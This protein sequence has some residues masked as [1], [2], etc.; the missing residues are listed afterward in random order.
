MSE[1]LTEKEFSD[2]GFTI[3][4]GAD[5]NGNERADD[6]VASADCHQLMDSKNVLVIRTSGDRLSVVRC[7]GHC[8]ACGRG[9]V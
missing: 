4:E 6:R 7:G 8:G 5:R 9:V 2:E 1:D 3:W